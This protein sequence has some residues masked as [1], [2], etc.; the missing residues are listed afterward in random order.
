M[1]IRH[2]L[3]QM[4]RR[5]PVCFNAPPLAEDVRCRCGAIAT[6]QWWPAVCALA[7][8]PKD[9][10]PLCAECDIKLN[11]HVVRC[12]YGNTREEYL[13]QYRAA[14]QPGRDEWE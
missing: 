9:W 5:E 10:I 4:L 14:A 11:E 8:A 6:E 12:L 3:G 2:M 1:S 7:D 13:A